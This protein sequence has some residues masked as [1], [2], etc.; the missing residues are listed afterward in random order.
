MESMES[1]KLL[2]TLPTPLGNPCGIPHYHGF[3]D[4]YHSFET[5][6][7]GRRKPAAKATITARGFETIFPV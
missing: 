3:G 1:Q 7:G 6:K 2:S 5:G 4:Y